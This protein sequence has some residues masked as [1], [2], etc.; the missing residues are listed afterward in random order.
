MMAQYGNA[1]VDNLR[2]FLAK[3]RVVGVGAEASGF[4]IDVVKVRNDHIEQYVYFLFDEGIK[5]LL[6]TLFKRVK[7]ERNFGKG[8]LAGMR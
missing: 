8:F 5:V 7:R 3:A 6:A 2:R 1:F 4:R